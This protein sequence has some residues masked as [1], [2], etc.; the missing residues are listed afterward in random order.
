MNVQANSQHHRLTLSRERSEPL[1]GWQPAL[2]AVPPF[3]T[4]HIAALLGVR[5]VG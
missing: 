2:C 3:E 5:W 4:L 1:E